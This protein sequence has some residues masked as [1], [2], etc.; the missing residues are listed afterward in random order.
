M[1]NLITIGD[2]VID[3]HVQIDDASL[4]CR[5]KNKPCQLCFD[6]ASKIPITD[7]FQSLGG[8]AANVAVGAT[9]LGL[10]TTIISSVGNDSNGQLAINELTKLNID[11]G[12]IYL[13]DKNQ[14]RYSIVLTFQGERTI[15]SFHKKRKYAWPEQMPATD[16]VYYTGLS[17]G[18]KN[19]KI[20]LIAWLKKH[21]TVRLAINPG[22]YQLKYHLDEVK[23]SI[24]KADILLVNLQEA[25]RILDT[26]LKKEKTVSAL[27]HGLLNLGAGEVVITDA[28]KGASVGSLEEIWQMESYP[29]NVVA[30]TGAGDAFSS[31]YVTA[32]CL[33]YNRPQALRWGIANSCSVITQVGAQNGLLTKDDLQKMLDKYPD[34]VPKPVVQT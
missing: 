29:I 21:P 12:Y 1:Y 32:R 17:A 15:L 23:E 28:Q 24:N 16:W 4:E 2:I 11:T 26:S 6:Y 30:K 3:T 22:S 8:N 14:T 25:E 20:N 5:L 33:G 34:I 31:G 18:F 13:E 10:K 9:K 19:I 7:S 27:I